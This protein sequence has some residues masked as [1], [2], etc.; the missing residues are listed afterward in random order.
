MRLHQLLRE[1]PAEL[2]ADLHDIGINL[3]DLYREDRP[4]VTF[5]RVKTLVSQL[6]PGSRVSQAAME[7]DA[8]TSA[9][10]FLATILDALQENTWA[11]VNRGVEKSKQSP[12]PDPIDRPSDARAER[13][14][15]RS[16]VEKARAFKRARSR[17]TP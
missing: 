9:D 7:D 13:D 16:M 5:R 1:F 2:E 12:H 6:R 3:V 10:Y 8:W 14:R 17:A 15:Q 4:E 11:T